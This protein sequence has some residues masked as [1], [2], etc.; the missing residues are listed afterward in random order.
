MRA[1]LIGFSMLVAV[2]CFSGAAHGLFRV[3]SFAMI[4]RSSPRTDA[5]SNNFIFEFI[6]GTIVDDLL[7][8][9]GGTVGA[10][11]IPLPIID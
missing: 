2:H 4:V 8:K 5:V 1:D 3:E 7:L 6:F 11:T 10:P 9:R